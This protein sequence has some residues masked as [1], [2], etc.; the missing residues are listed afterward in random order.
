MFPWIAHHLAIVSG[1]VSIADGAVV[2]PGVFI[3]NGQ[4]VIY[5]LVEIGPGVTLLPWLT[6]GPI[7]GGFIGPKIAVT[8]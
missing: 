6:V 4:V 5:G 2:H 8:E 3:P 7:A 1:Q